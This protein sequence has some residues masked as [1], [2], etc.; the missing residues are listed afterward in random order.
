MRDSSAFSSTDRLDR[1]SGLDDFESVTSDG[2]EE[3]PEDG[4]DDVVDADRADG[5]ADATDVR[6][7]G[8]TNVIGVEDPITSIDMSAEGASAEGAS[9][10]RC[11]VTPTNSLRS[12]I[13]SR[14]NSMTENSDPIPS[15]DSNTPQPSPANSC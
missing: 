9:A 12:W 10:D 13:I 15:S 1:D 7:E 3:G 4:L 5:L 14:E 6:A 11:S 8:R 2:P